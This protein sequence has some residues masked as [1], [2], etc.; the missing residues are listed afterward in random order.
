MLSFTLLSVQYIIHVDY[1]E[2]LHSLVFII[3]VFLLSGS[4]PSNCNGHG[5]CLPNG[6]CEC[7]NGYTGI[8]CATG[9]DISLLQ[10]YFI[11]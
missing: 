9:I 10:V 1:S 6:V 2:I 3:Y 11:Y 8:D 4:C 5:K 7:V